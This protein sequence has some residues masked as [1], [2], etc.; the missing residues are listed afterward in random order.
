MI[1]GQKEQEE[2]ARR[3]EEY[4]DKIIRELRNY[5][6][7]SWSHYPPSIEDVA[8]FVLRER[9]GFDFTAIELENIALKAIK[10]DIGEGLSQYVA[11][12]PIRIAM[13]AIAKVLAGK[14]RHKHI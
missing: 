7:L 12:K 6:P 1:Y 13:C 3:R 8:E 4:L 2:F 11:R 10:E 5:R 9:E 14:M